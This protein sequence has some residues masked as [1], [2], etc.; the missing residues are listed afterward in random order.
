MPL[1]R[2][3]IEAIT[4]ELEAPLQ[5][6]RILTI[7]RRDDRSAILTLRLAKG[8]GL[9]GAEPPRPRRLF[10]LVCARPGFARAH[11]VADPFA[12]PAAPPGEFE[13]LRG[14]LRGARILSIR[15]PGRGRAIEIDVEV[16]RDAQAH[17]PQR[18]GAERKRTERRILVLELISSTPNVVLLDERRHYLWSLR[19]V[20]D[21]RSP[22]SRSG[23]RA[24]LQPGE[25]Y[26]PR[27]PPPHPAAMAAVAALPWR[28]LPQN[29]A[30]AASLTYIERNFPL[31]LALG[32]SSGF[33]EAAALR[34]V[35]RA[36][37]LRSLKTAASKRR[38]LLARLEE[39]LGR[40]K[41]GEKRL[42]WG[43]L[44]KS[45][46]PRLRRGMGRVEV[47]DYYS[48]E[49]PRIE[50]PLDPALSPLENIQRCFQIHRKAQRALPAIRTR[51]EQVCG[52]LARIEDL[53]SAVQKEPGA[54]ET[55][56]TELQDLERRAAPLLRREPGKPRAPAAPGAK[57]SEERPGP[58]GSPRETGRSGPRRFIS[59][60][61]FQILVGRSA[62]EN[63][64][65]T[66]RFAKGNDLFFH[67]AGRPGA[68][69]LVRTLPGRSVPL[70]TLLDAAQLALYYSL[71]A[72]DS[73]AIERGAAADID[74]VEVKHV[75]KPKGAKAG[76][77]LLSR[78]RTLRAEIEKERLAR[79]RETGGQE[80]TGRQTPGPADRHQERRSQGR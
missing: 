74:Y 25:T 32:R 20:T 44:L 38:T 41:E 55:G 53:A 27:S 68:H 36:A 64:R 72:R 43:E 42:R 61:G 48:A 37:L 1:S 22:E 9:E 56:E 69:V 73:A 58:A 21:R 47:I 23:P 63:D 31:N 59:L 13:W 76:L 26:A 17:V 39:D 5:G 29:D 70:E 57:G 79:L 11:L 71:P 18:K 49:L 8:R 80:T 14:R 65:L 52:D 6:A 2:E 35:R 33:A 15:R 28:Y 7:T 54:G 34:E 4:R 12:S 77:V 75:R 67:V 51:M 19:P 10:L 30:L 40:A 50:I 78:H 66:F 45:E 24:A 16:R 62:E 60:D 46:L 3:E